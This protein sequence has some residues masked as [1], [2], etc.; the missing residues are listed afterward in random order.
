MR[1]FFI[2][3]AEH[4]FAGYKPDNVARKF[5]DSTEEIYRG[6]STLR[7]QRRKRL[8]LTQEQKSRR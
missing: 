6:S 1:N 2:R 3:R 5:E 4:W 8:P 7:R